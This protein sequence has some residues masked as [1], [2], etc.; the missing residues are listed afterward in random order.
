MLAL[1]QDAYQCVSPPIISDGIWSG[2]H[3]LTNLKYPPLTNSADRPPA[4][5]PHVSRSR[6][7][8]RSRVAFLFSAKGRACV[9][10]LSRILVPACRGTRTPE[11]QRQAPSPFPGRKKSRSAAGTNR[12]RATGRHH[13]RRRQTHP[14]SSCPRCRH[15]QGRA[16]SDP[17]RRPPPTATPEPHLPPPPPQEQVYSHAQRAAAGPERHCRRSGDQE[18]RTGTSTHGFWA[19]YIIIIR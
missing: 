15:R 10:A 16:D 4:R 18:F 7:Q 1:Q 9:R 11:R 2:H 6:G 12:K 19:K 13:G 14:V 17:I 8:R 5:G 3:S